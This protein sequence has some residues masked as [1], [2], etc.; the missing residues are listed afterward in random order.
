MNMFFPNYQEDEYCMSPYDARRYQQLQRQRQMEEQRQRDIDRYYHE[1]E[2][3]QLVKQREEELRRRQMMIDE[4]HRRLEMEQMRR[5]QERY[6]SDD[7]A[8]PT[9]VR[10]SDGRLY[11]SR[12][13]GR[14][15]GDGSTTP[16]IVRGSDG[17]LYG[18]I[19]RKDEKSEDRETNQQQQQQPSRQNQYAK[20]PTKAGYDH[21]NSSTT[22]GL[23]KF[24][25]QNDNHHKKRDRGSSVLRFQ[26]LQNQR[27]KFKGSKSTNARSR[28]LRRITITVEDAS[29]SEAEDE[30]TSKWRNRRPSPEE[31]WMEPISN[32]SL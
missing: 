14:H 10:G 9:I 6:D 22:E 28:N 32:P 26:S 2:L 25:L 8:T 1:R 7:S 17:R 11:R 3:R 4:Q 16:T 20:T 21:A 27:D 23:S 19:P 5:Q 13:Q 29:D 30:Y 24:G 12:Q 18:L 31:S 15:D